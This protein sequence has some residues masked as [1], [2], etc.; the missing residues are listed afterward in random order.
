MH[1]LHFKIYNIFC[2]LDTKLYFAT[3]KISLAGKKNEG[4]KECSLM[5]GSRIQVGWE[6][7]TWMVPGT[8]QML[9]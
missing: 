9:H 1:F 8:Y 6:T 7:Q 2:F 3:Y 5:M 4:F